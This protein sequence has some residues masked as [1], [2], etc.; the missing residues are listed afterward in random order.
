MSRIV[1][2]IC[3]ISP[4]KMATTFKN[5]ALVFCSVHVKLLNDS[6]IS[7]FK[8]YENRRPLVGGL[9]KDMKRNEESEVPVQMQTYFL[10]ILFTVRKVGPEKI[11][12]QFGQAAVPRCEY[13]YYTLSEEK[14][15]TGDGWMKK[16]RI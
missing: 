16:C 6:V 7:C 1:C 4:D 9:Q 10:Y 12:K 13:E 2:T 3:S 14:H 11:W 8:Y 15:F 5:T